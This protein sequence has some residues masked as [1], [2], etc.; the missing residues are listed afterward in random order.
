MSSPVLVAYDKKLPDG[1]N[2]PM[3]C[4]YD[5]SSGMTCSEP[6]YG[7]GFANDAVQTV[8][9]GGT[10]DDVRKTLRQEGYAFGVRPDMLLEQHTASGAARL[11]ANDG[12]F[13]CAPTLTADKKPILV[14]ASPQVAPGPAVSLTDATMNLSS[15]ACG[16]TN[17]EQHQILCQK[18]TCS[19]AEK[20]LNS[21]SCHMTQNSTPEGQF[22]LITVVG[23]S[24]NNSAPA[25]EDKFDTEIEYVDVSVCARPEFKSNFA[26]CV[27]KRERYVTNRSTCSGPGRCM[28]NDGTPFELS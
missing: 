3:I 17:E 19:V 22:Q 28:Q 5:E 7:G 25:M 26:G 12:A 14:A 11:C 6:L 9:Q 23:T 2:V 15:T 8:M 20:M 21:L 1:S 4:R 18:P 10:T 16:N 27:A 24:V 13:S